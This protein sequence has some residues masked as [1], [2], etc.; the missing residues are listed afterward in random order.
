METSVIIYDD[1]AE[2]RTQYLRSVS[3]KLSASANLYI[4]F[5]TKAQVVEKT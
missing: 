1:P 4:A 2:I 5:F 3:Q